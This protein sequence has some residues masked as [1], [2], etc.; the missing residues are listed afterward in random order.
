ML[1]KQ[2][3]KSPNVNNVHHRPITKY[4]EMSKVGKKQLFFSPLKRRQ[5]SQTLFTPVLMQSIVPPAMA[6]PRGGQ[7]AVVML[8]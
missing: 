2:Q 7:R 6:A 4:V 8:R 3:L 1:V 5:H